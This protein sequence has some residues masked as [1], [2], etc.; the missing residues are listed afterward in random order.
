MVFQID[1]STITLN[2]RKNNSDK[3]L[4]I[5]SLQDVESLFRYSNEFFEV[6]IRNT[7]ETG[8]LAH[9]LMGSIAE[10]YTLN[11]YYYKNICI[12]QELEQ[13]DLIHV[14]HSLSMIRQ[15]NSMPRE[16]FQIDFTSYNIASMHCT[17]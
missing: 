1:V 11:L 17:S 9:M 6:F 14:S 12:D 15:G 2:L 10:L 13:K 3:T 5:F 16:S 4:K 8:L 7:I